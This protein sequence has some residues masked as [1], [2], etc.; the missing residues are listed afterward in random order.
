MTKLIDW[1]APIKALAE[2]LGLKKPSANTPPSK[3]GK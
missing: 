3:G 2:L 1:K